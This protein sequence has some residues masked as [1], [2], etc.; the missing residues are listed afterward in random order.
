MKL[1]SRC[2]PF[3]F[4]SAFAAQIGFAQ[5]VPV[6][7]VSASSP[8]SVTVRATYLVM[9]DSSSPKIPVK[10]ED[11]L[12]PEFDIEYRLNENWALE[13]VLSVPQEHDVK[14]G[15]TSLGDFKHLPPTLLLKYY[16]GEFAGFRPYVGAGANFTLIFDE[17][18]SNG[19]LKLD[20]YS[21]GPAAQVGVEYDL[22]ERWSLNLDVKRIMLRTDVKTA[23][24]VKVSEL[25]VDPWLLAIG[26]KYRF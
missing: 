17:N 5:S 25:E 24:G 18:L 26:V 23:A 21:V 14:L 11:K 20:N 13:L 15:G 9:S 1:K 2:L 16:A 10:I 19:G 22:G 3:L 12:I 6:E 8:W 4:L 7:T